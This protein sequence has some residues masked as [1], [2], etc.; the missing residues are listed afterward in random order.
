[1]GGRVQS[2]LLGGEREGREAGTQDPRYAEPRGRLGH[3]REPGRAGRPSATAGGHSMG[4]PGLRRRGLAAGGGAPRAP[5]PRFGTI[6]FR[7]D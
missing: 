2:L 6:H 7:P 1:M 4:A 3:Q 5:K